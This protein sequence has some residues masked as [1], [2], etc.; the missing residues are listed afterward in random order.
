MPQA[1]GAS[2]GGAARGS[3]LYEAAYLR[4]VGSQPAVR[5]GWS[6]R[7]RWPETHVGPTCATGVA[8]R[9]PEVYGIDMGKRDPGGAMRDGR[10]RARVRARSRPRCRVH[11]KRRF[12]SAGIGVSFYGYRHY[13]PP[14]GRWLS[15]DPIGERGDRNLMCMCG[16]NVV[17]SRDALGLKKC[18]VQ[19][20][21]HPI[22]G[23]R[24]LV[25]VL[26]AA[27]ALS[28]ANGQASVGPV[29]TNTVY[30]LGAN[31]TTNA[32]V[33]AVER[34]GKLCLTV[35]RLAD[36]SGQRHFYCR[37]RYVLSEADEDGDGFFET[38]ML[39]GFSSLDFEF[40]RR[41]RRGDVF[42]LS[43]HGM[44]EARLKRMKRELETVKPKNIVDE[45]KRTEQTGTNTTP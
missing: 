27:L 17:C 24:V 16:N 29:V 18:G 10:N 2:A 34:G 13:A 19:R 15:R 43:E 32:V 33:V 37:G 25:S 12:D 8:D 35:V 44:T 6:A 36:G 28:Q 39:S 41:D 38:I 31:G 5:S 11:R 21:S 1:L 23:R 4:R 45:S 14:M 20:P 26:A 7:S 42:P 40:F 30:R 3:R 9:R 22:R